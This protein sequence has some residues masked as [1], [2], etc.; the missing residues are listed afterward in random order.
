[1]GKYYRVYLRDINKINKQSNLALKES[2][3]AVMDVND[4]TADNQIQTLSEDDRKESGEYN[5]G[6][7][8]SL[9]FA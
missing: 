2:S 1:M 9:T 4:S 6:D 3:Q 7:Q 8:M 5:A